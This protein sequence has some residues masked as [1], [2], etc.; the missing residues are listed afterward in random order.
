MSLKF[1]G[2][3]NECSVLVIAKCGESGGWS[4]FNINFWP[5]VRRQQ[6]HHYK[7]HCHDAL[8][9]QYFQ[10]MLVCCVTFF[11]KLKVNS[12]LAIKRE[13]KD[14][15]GLSSPESFMSLADTRPFHGN[16]TISLCE[17]VQL[18]SRFCLSLHK[19]RYWCVDPTCHSF[20]HWDKNTHRF[21]TTAVFASRTHGMSWF[22]FPAWEKV[23]SPSLCVQI[24]FEAHPAFYPIGSWAFFYE[25]KVWAGQDADHS[26]PSNVE[27]SNEEELHLNT[28][29]RPSQ[30]SSCPVAG[31]IDFYFTQ[32]LD[33][34]KMS[35]IPLNFC[36]WL[37]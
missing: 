36:I 19:I 3:S 8:L 37:W 9:C 7:G 30:I 34:F 17:H 4:S 14:R 29:P 25:S 12:S 31:Q 13:G 20:S 32:Q 26:L 16:S 15:Q 28:P 2:P 5:K 27:V 11:N 23:S 1:C 22:W 18:H 35:V 33:Q 10:I 6:V 24:G 21:A